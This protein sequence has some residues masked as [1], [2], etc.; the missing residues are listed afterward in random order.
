MTSP[1]RGRAYANWRRS[2]PSTTNRVV[3]DSAFD[4][5]KA[6][7]AAAITRELC[8]ED[9]RKACNRP[10][11]VLLL[12]VLQELI[13]EKIV[14]EIKS[15]TTPRYAPVRVKTAETRSLRRVWAT[16]A[17]CDAINNLLESMRCQKP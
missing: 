17:E 13:D 6:R 8:W 12:A 1:A 4:D 11:S 14:R 9:I 15:V 7:A 3:F 10:S 2:V 16:D 5:V